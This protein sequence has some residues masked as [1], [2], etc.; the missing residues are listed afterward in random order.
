MA[1]VGRR[2]FDDLRGRPGVGTRRFGRLHVGN[3]HELLGGGCL[4]GRAFGGGRFGGR[5]LARCGRRLLSRRVRS[6]PSGGRRGG[7]CPSLRPLGGR[8]WPLRRGDLRRGARA[9]PFRRLR[10]LRRRSLRRVSERLERR[11][12]NISSRWSRRRL[13]L[14][15]WRRLLRRSRGF[16][17]SPAARAD[18]SRSDGRSGCPRGLRRRPGRSG[19]GRRREGGRLLH[20]LER[21]QPDAVLCGRGRSPRQRRVAD[22]RRADE[23]S[24]GDP[25]LLG[26]HLSL[27]F[28]L[29]RRGSRPGVGRR[30]ARRAAARPLRSG[31][32]Q[33]LRSLR[34]RRPRQRRREVRDRI[35]VYAV[36]HD[37][38][39]SQ[40]RLV[41][42]L[43]ARAKVEP[44]D[45]G[46]Q[47][48]AVRLDAVDREHA[49]SLRARPPHDARQMSNISAC[50]NWKRA[51]EARAWIRIGGIEVYLGRSA[52]RS[53][54][55]GERMF[56]IIKKA[57]RGTT[58]EAANKNNERKRL[59]NPTQAK[60]KGMNRCQNSFNS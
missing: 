57:I 60:K 26:A 44:V 6:G 10:W 4:L 16:G 59:L 56:T 37:V 23:H 54:R 7:R 13:G 9:R 31:R 19:G 17:S 21:L 43:A 34:P 12:G 14:R 53:W 55:A 27:A 52:L 25:L 41:L 48:R 22:S 32:R 5:L 36:V 15:L 45:A 50:L 39:R 24:V 29:Q 40:R 28:R 30:R 11:H 51:R 35:L 49:H 38:Q 46:A 47:M 8:G 42:Q 33:S 2:D 18:R 1:Q 20:R 3:R 58:C